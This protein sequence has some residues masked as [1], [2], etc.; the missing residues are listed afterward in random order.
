MV[1]RS[2]SGGTPGVFSYQS[3]R[4]LPSA[5]E[6]LNILCAAPEEVK[7]ILGWLLC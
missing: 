5:L 2:T 7:E 4:T 3:P 6:T 1:Y